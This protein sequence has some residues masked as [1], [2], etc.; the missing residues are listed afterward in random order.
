MID[1][2]SLSVIDTLLT[3]KLL[4]IGVVDELHNLSSVEAEFPAIVINDAVAPHDELQ[5]KSQLTT[6]V[7]DEIDFIISFD[8]SDDEYYTIFFDKKS[9]YYKMISVNDL[10]T[11]SENDY[12]KVMPSIPLPEPAISCFDDLDFFTDFENKFLAIVYI[13]AETSKSDLLTEPIL[14]PQHIDEFDLNDKTSLSEYDKEEQNV[15]YFNDL[16][17]FNIIRPDNLKSE[18]D[19]DESKIDIILS[20]E[21]KEYTH[22]STTVFETSHDKKTKNFRPGNFVINLN[23]GIVIWIHYANGMLFFLI[24]N[25]C[26]PFGIP[27]DPKCYYK[28]G[29]CSKILRRPGTFS[30]LYFRKLGLQGWIR[31]IRIKPIRHIALPPREQRHRFLRYEGLEYPD[32]DISDFEGRLARIHRREVHRVP[33]FDFGGLL[34]LM[35]KGLSGRMLVEHRDKAGVSVFT[36]RA[37]R[38]M[39]DI[40]G[41]LVHELILE[42]FGTFRF[43]QAILDLDT[44]GTL[45]FQLGGAR[46]RMSW[47]QF[48][49]ALGLH[50]EEEMHTWMGISSAGDFLGTT[51]SYTLIRDPILRLCHRLIAYSIVGRSQAP[52]KVTVTN[53]FYLRG[54]DVGLVNIPYLLA[55]CLRLF[56]AGRK[57]GAHI[58]G[59]QFVARLTEHFGLLTAEILGGLTICAQFDDTWAWVAM[60]LE[61]QPVAA[62]GALAVAED[63]PIIYEGGQADPA[64]EQAPHQPPSPPPADARTMPQRMARLEEVVHEIRRGLTEQREVFDATAYDF[65]RFNTWVT[66]RLGRMMDRAGVTY[67]PYA[68]THVSY[69]RRV[70]QR[71]GKANTS[72][73]QQDLQ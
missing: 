36:S 27:F 48:I 58:S 57:S 14:N 12:E 73:A 62:A 28:D 56:S 15:L 46:R 59:G 69:Q 51:P 50:T 35:A 8:E 19:N 67:T 2:T 44:L 60:G 26:A 64:P 1:L 9:F 63:A 32:T 70:R 16:F 30:L 52:E 24:K 31:R 33:V 40:R 72:A 61:R 10:K 49:L 39:L 54:M 41:P 65:S 34:D 17:S 7:N 29:V 11:Y 66:T 25:L 37:W 20:F 21:D 6:P 22:G 3:T 45:Q 71:T 23:L 13:D 38:R 4:P 47:R 42:F 18:K 43:G 5:C 55:R 68:Q 53:L